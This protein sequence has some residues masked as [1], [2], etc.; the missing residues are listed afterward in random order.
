VYSRD[1]LAGTVGL[2]DM[3]GDSGKRIILCEIEIPVLMLND[4]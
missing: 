3:L 4:V 2:A 1:G